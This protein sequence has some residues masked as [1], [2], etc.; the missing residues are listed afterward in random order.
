MNRLLQIFSRPYAPLALGVLFAAAL[1]GAY[2]LH[3]V[4]P[5]WAAALVTALAAVVFV[6]VIIIMTQIV[7]G[8]REVIL[9]VIGAGGVVI[10]AIALAAAFPP[11]AP[12]NPA[13]RDRLV[14]LFLLGSI[15]IYLVL[16]LAGRRGEF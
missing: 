6:G 2:L 1:A 4:L 11:P 14:Q 5:L 13:D 3:F 7:N 12:V 15:F 8:W 16:G 10:V 9:F